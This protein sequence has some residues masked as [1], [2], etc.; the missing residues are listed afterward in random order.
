M[1]A[2][3]VSSLVMVV[4]NHSILHVLSGIDVEVFFS[5]TGSGTSVMKHSSM[6]TFAFGW[7]DK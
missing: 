4:G 1:M 6:Y 7:D 5:D 3:S 2:V